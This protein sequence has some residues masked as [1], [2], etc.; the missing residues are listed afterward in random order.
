MSFGPDL[1]DVWQIVVKLY[2]LS[3][4]VSSIYHHWVNLCTSVLFSKCLELTLLTKH[5]PLHLRH[6]K[7]CSVSGNTLYRHCA[8]NSCQQSAGGFNNLCMTSSYH[9]I[10]KLY[11]T[12]IYTVYVYCLWLLLIY[13][14]S[15]TWLYLIKKAC[16]VWE[17]EFS[18]LSKYPKG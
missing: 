6:P 10:S 15:L 2:F 16:I 5:F 1:L 12:D 11:Y 8:G 7:L 9:Q 3:W 14:E 18:T 4:P 13:W 17:N